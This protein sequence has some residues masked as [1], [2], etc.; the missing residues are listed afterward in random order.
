M[1]NDGYS[2][3]RYWLSS[4]NKAERCQDVEETK[5]EVMETL[6][7]SPAYHMDAK[8]NGIAQPIVAVRK[9]TNICNVT[10]IPGDR[11]YIGDEVQV[12]NEHWICVELHTDE[13]GVT[14]GELWMCNQI[15]RYQLHNGEVVHRYAIIDDGSYSKATEKAVNIT[16]NTYDCYISL[17]EETRQLYI[18][19]RLAI[20]VILNAKGEEI[21]EV[22]KI[23]WLD[24]KSKNYGVGSH[25]LFFTIERDVYSKEHD[26]LENLICDYRITEAKKEEQ[27][28]SP[29][30]SLTINGKPQIRIGTGRSYSANAIDSYGNSL[31]IDGSDIEWIIE[32]NPA[33]S[34]KV[35]GG[36]CIIEVPFEEAHVGST[37]VIKCTDSLG[38][39]TYATK[40]VEV[41][42]VG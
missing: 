25:L 24:F 41:V 16:E 4:T 1:T 34:C 3:Y 30:G 2:V 40:E 19:K 38:R 42:G 5:E 17:D 39:Y 10:V 11:L 12:F 6:M 36:K 23:S 15:F 31:E 7:E 37:F 35:D 33:V 21:L 32:G 8:V 26:D 27:E 28:S 18:D 22:G 14:S 20:D 9:K 29:G 13:Y